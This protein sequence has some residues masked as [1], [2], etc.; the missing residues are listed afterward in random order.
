MRNLSAPLEVFEPRLRSTRQQDAVR[1]KLDSAKLAAITEVFYNIF[2]IGTT[3]AKP[4]SGPFIFL[5]KAIQLTGTCIYCA[6]TVPDFIEKAIQ[7]VK[8]LRKSGSRV[9][10]KARLNNFL[11]SVNVFGPNKVK[12]IKNIAIFTLQALSWSLFI[13]SFFVMPHVAFILCL[14]ASAIALGLGIKD[15]YFKYRANLE[16]V[17]LLSRY[18]V[19]MS[20]VF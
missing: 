11:K 4:F 14:T 3:I 12:A 19:Y 7:K 5:V 8:D 13:A 10:L 1:T 16:E 20:N 9:P 17:P 18:P 15:L 6:L 2:Y